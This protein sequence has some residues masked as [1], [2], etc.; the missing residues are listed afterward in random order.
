MHVEVV[1]F[2]NGKAR[3]KAGLFGISVVLQF[4]SVA[5]DREWYIYIKYG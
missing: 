2:R 4:S 1:F 3:R 5:V